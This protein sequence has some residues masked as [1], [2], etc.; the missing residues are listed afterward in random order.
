MAGWDGGLRGGSLIVMVSV[1]LFVTLSVVVVLEVGGGSWIDTFLKMD[2]VSIWQEP[3]GFDST[4]LADPLSQAQ[5]KTA[6]VDRC[7]F[8]VLP[9]S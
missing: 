1:L 5:D 7:V 2:D 3:S 8:R 9:E 4:W 6:G